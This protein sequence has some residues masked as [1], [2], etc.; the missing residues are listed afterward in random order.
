L[1]WEENL[2]YEG[3][4]TLQCGAVVEKPETLIS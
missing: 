1:E 3:A 4:L 2:Q